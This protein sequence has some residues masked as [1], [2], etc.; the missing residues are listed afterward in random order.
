MSWNRAGEKGEKETADKISSTLFQPAKRRM[1]VTNILFWHILVCMEMPTEK[2]ENQK[3][4]DWYD[5][6][7]LPME[8]HSFY[9]ARC[10]FTVDMANNRDMKSIGLRCGIKAIATQFFF[11]IKKRIFSG[12]KNEILMR[13]PFDSFGEAEN[14]ICIHFPRTTGTIFN[15]QY[16]NTVPLHIVSRESGVKLRLRVTF[17]LEL[18]AA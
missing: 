10:C 8:R 9:P 11:F 16:K 15:M 5:L 3:R 6:I 17:A 2:P 1:C 18:I 13:Y 12:K 14:V 4:K 7:I